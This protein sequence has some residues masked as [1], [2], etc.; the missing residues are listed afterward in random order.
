MHANSCR[1]I[2]SYRAPT[3]LLIARPDV[4][5]SS[6]K[7]KHEKEV[8]RESN[9]VSKKKCLEHR[10]AKPV[11]H[12]IRFSCVVSFPSLNWPPFTPTAVLLRGPFCLPCYVTLGSKYNNNMATDS[13]V[14]IFLTWGKVAVRTWSEDGADRQWCRIAFMSRCNDD[15]KRI[16]S[17]H[18]NLQAILSDVSNPRDEATTCSPTFLLNACQWKKNYSPIRQND[19]FLFLLALSFPWFIGSSV[20]SKFCARRARLYRILQSR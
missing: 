1:Y 7:R 19:F 4:S 17:K 13:I 10:Y 14:A 12:V 15:F 5:W 18:F 20:Y 8:D 3:M 11:E 9:R 2:W 6:K 16:F